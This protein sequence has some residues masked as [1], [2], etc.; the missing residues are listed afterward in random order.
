MNRGDGPIPLPRSRMTFE[1]F[2]ALPRELRDAL[3]YA[4]FK[5]AIPDHVPDHQ[6]KARAAR[7]FTLDAK[8][9]AASKR[10]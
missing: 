5:Y 1:Q 6:A 9:I 3:N 4:S 2:D 10:K 7:L 8:Q